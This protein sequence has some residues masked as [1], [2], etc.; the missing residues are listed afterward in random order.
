VY[1]TPK[2]TTLVVPPGNTSISQNDITPSPDGESLGFFAA[3]AL[4]CS[5]RLQIL[6]DC[7][8]RQ[9]SFHGWC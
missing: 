5:R 3:E 6:T 4:F 1:S 7:L 9:L 2:G 8:R